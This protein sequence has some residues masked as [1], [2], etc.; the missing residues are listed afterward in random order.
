MAIPRAARRAGR[1]KAVSVMRLVSPWTNRDDVRDDARD[2]ES[3]GEASSH[4]SMPRSASSSV[5]SSSTPQHSARG[6]R[7]AE[8]RDDA[9]FRRYLK[10]SVKESAT[11]IS[12]AEHAEHADASSGSDDN[13]LSDTRAVQKRGARVNKAVGGDQLP[14]LTRLHAD[15]V[16]DAD[17]LSSHR[18]AEDEAE[19]ELQFSI[20]RNTTLMKLLARAA[21]ISTIVTAYYI[22]VIVA[23]H[24]A[25]TTLEDNTLDLELATR[26][27][28]LVELS[29]LFT[30]EHLLRDFDASIEDLATDPLVQSGEFMVRGLAALAE[31]S[32]ITHEVIFGNA[33]KGIAPPRRSSRY[34]RVMFQNAC[35]MDRDDIER[36]GIDVS[37]YFWDTCSSFDSGA[38]T[39]GLYSNMLEI[40]STLQSLLRPEYTAVVYTGG[41]AVIDPVKF[42]YAF[43]R[44]KY[45]DMMLHD[46]LLPPLRYTTE[47]IKQESIVEIEDFNA[48]R[49]VL[50]L[51]YLCVSL[52]AY[53]IAVQP[54]VALL[55]TT[56]ARSHAMLLLLPPA[57]IKSSVA[58]Q[59]YVAD[60]EAQL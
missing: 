36:L 42:A 49:L 10:R 44:L 29:Y 27:Y 14:D 58:A 9:V 59:R 22:F 38:M 19:P 40:S 34:D 47:M 41:G 18:D 16:R 50:L 28:P 33:E 31:A 35:D 26:R 21:L 48:L 2:E 51:S 56:S 1:R 13:D 46:Y 15:L 39:Q 45:L 5:A 24:S 37:Q 20:L 57:I 23:T 11:L 43:G 17:A 53:S 6:S 3:D 25:L 52:S 12:A 4:D 30:R 60:N 55:R 54:I 8:H 7:R 32:S